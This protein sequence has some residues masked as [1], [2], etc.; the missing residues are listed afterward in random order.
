M[1]FTKKDTDAVNAIRF[2]SVDM[3]E[4][5]KSGHPG[6]PIDAAPMAYVLWEKFMNFN[7]KEPRWI[8]RDRFVLSAGHG[9]AML[10]SL[11][12]LNCFN[13]PIDELKQFRQLHSKTPGHPEYGITEVQRLQLV[14]QGTQ[15]MVDLLRGSF[16]AAGHNTKEDHI[17]LLVAFSPGQIVDDHVC[18]TAGVWS[19]LIKALEPVDVEGK[20]QGS[21]L[22][23]ELSLIGTSRLDHILPS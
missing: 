9:S 22:V 11:L 5:A 12:H 21:G 14:D 2:L 10:Y 18:R 13:L 19:T 16:L 17:F 15:I 7:P 8:N 4:K 20:H 1:K 23:D 3:I 6:L